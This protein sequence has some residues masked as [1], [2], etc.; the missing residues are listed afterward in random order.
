LNTEK[1]QPGLQKTDYFE[2]IGSVI[3]SKESVIG[4][5]KSVRSPENV[6]FIEQAL[7]WIPIKSRTPSLNNSA[8]EHHQHAG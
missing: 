1:H 7:M 8:W 5:K 2:V 3:N 6:Y 4:K